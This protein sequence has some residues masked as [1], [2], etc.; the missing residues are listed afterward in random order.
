MKLRTF[1]LVAA[2]MLSRPTY[3]DD[4]DFR[5]NQLIYKEHS[6]YRNIL[7]IKNKTHICMSFGKK[8]GMQS[9]SIINNPDYLV[10][11]Y[12]KGLMA[13]LYLKPDIKNVLIIGMGGGS[14]PKAFRSYNPALIIDT[15][16]LDPAV[17]E[18]AYKYFKYTPDSRSTVHIND[19]RVFV[20]SEIRK[21]RQYDLILIDAFDK[22]YIPEHMLTREFLTQIKSILSKSGIVA[23]NTF[24]AGPLARSETATYQSV[25]GDIY[26]MPLNGGN[27]ILFASKGDFPSIPQALAAA[28]QLEAKLRPLGVDPTLLGALYEEE[29]VEGG[30]IF[31]D[32]YSPANLMLRAD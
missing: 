16:E 1:L 2:V 17:A 29:R 5:V 9:C 7:V 20:R 3:A 14:L 22:D 31:T 10:L 18:V 30:Q 12:T 24:T 4:E 27:S 11:N 32:Q 6:L 15:V 19:G 21:H 23:A 13:S 28:Q 26:K 25:F 8:Q